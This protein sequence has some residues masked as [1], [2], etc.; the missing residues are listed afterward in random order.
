MFL[1]IRFLLVL[2]TYFVYFIIQ[3]STIDSAYHSPI[4]FLDSLYH[5]CFTAL[6][7]LNFIIS[8][9]ISLPKHLKHDTMSVHNII[10]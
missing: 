3:T 5:F 7:I 2:L 6:Y 8:F 9:I 4:T 10:V 1:R